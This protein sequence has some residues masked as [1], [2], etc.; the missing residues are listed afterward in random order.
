MSS[1]PIPIDITPKPN[2]LFKNKK[3]FKLKENNNNYYF[4][5]SF[6]D[7]LILFEI[8]KVNEFPKKDYSVYLDLSQLV[9]INKYFSQFESITE[10]QSSFETLIEM[11]KLSI[12]NDEKE[13]KLQIINPLNK[14]EFYISIPLKEKTFKNEIDTLIPYISSLNERITKMENRINSLENKVN[15]LYSIKEEYFKLKRKEIEQNYNLFP[16]SSIIKKGEEN[17]ILSWFDKKP[18][19]F[20]LLFDT[21]INGDSISTFYKRCQNKTPTILFFK[22]TNGARFGGYTTSIWANKGSLKDENSFVFSLD[23]KE[24]YNVINKSSAIYCYENYF[25]FGTCCFR[26]YNKCTSTTDNYI[27][28]GKKHYDIPGNYE[29]TG[30]DQKF[31]ISSYEVYQLEF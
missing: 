26:I 2:M 9:N 21:N 7:Q 27:N 31:T 6:N 24:K 23:K 19:N 14:N 18:K 3:T 17:T 1:A 28:D 11:G 20:K 10:I 30:G 5:L 13:I 12:I 8:E 29:L 25:Q 16:E 4:S 22:T 15:E